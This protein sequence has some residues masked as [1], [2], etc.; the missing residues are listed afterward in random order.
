MR[1]FLFL[2]AA[3][4]LGFAQFSNAQQLKSFTHDNEKYIEELQGFFAQGDSKAAKK[5]IEETF[6]P[7]WNSGHYSPQQKERVYKM[8]DLMLKE[9]KKAVDF[10]NY[11]YALMSFATS[12]KPASDFEAFHDGM[13]QTI[14][15]LS[16][17]G[18]TEYLEVCKGLFTDHILFDSR[19]VKWVA[20]YDAY[21]I[22]FDS[23][24]KIVFGKLDLKAYSKRDSSVIYGTEGVYY[25]TLTKWVGKGGKVDWRRAGFD[26]N[27]TYADIDNYVIN[28]T[29]SQYAIDSVTFHHPDYLDRPH[30][31]ILTEK[32]LAD[33]DTSDA[34]YPRF[35]SYDKRIR[36][37]NMY[38][39]I[40]YAGGFSQHGIKFIG[41]GDADQ[42]ATLI[43]KKKNHITKENEDFLEARAKSFVIRPDKVLS[44]KAEIA[45]YYEG[46]SIY[47]PGLKLNYNV[48]DHELTLS[49]ERE[50][51]GRS[52]FFDSYHKVDM[53]VDEI[54]WPMAEDWMDLANTTGGAES[55]ALF[56]SETYYD[57]YRYDRLAGT[58]D[59]HPL[60]KI[61]N[62]AKQ[63]GM[64]ELSV[65]QVAS[66]FKADISDT[67]VFLM[68]LSNSG[69]MTYNYDKERVVIKPRLHH[70]VLSRSK[71]TDYDIL[72]FESTIEGMPNAKLNLLN[73]DMDMNGVGR[74]FLSDSQNVVIF[75]YE[76]EL[77][78]KKNRDFAFDGKVIGGRLD[79]FGHE[80]YFSFDDFKI[81]LNKIDSLRLKVPDGVPDE[82]GRQK[83]RAVKTVLRDLT[84]ELLVDRPD[85]KSGLVDHSRYPVFN[86]TDDSF[87]YYDKRSIQDGVYDKEKFYMHLKPFSIDSLEN[88]TKEGLSFGGNFVSAGIFPDFEETLTLQPDF[89]LGFVRET[90]PDGLDMYGGK[91]NYKATIKLSH[92]GLR[93]DGN[94][95]YLTSVSKSDDFIFYPDSVNGVAQ[96]FTIAKQ[97][98]PTPYPPVVG[99]DV[100]V[101]W[102]PKLDHFY[103]YKIDNAFD[104]YEGEV[105]HH[106][107]LDLSPKGLDGFGN[108]DFADSY[109]RSDRFN[110]KYRDFHADS[111]DFKLK[112][113]SATA[114]A[115][116]TAN[117][118]MDIDLNERK[119]RFKSN[120]GGDFVDFPVNQYICYIDEFVWNI[121]AKDIDVVSEGEGSRYVSTSPGQDSLE[122]KSPL[123]KFDLN[124]FII[125]AEKVDH[126]DVADAIIYP[127]SGKVTIRQSAKMD[128]LENSK[129]V[130]NRITKFHTFYESNVNVLG[131]YNYNGNGKYDYEDVTGGKQL[132]DFATIG[133]D[134]AKQTFAVG[135]IT[136]EAA[137]TLSPNFDYK[138]KAKL[139][140]SQEHLTYDGSTRIKHDCPGITR[141]WLAFEANIDPNEIYIPIPDDPKDAS[142]KP[143]SSGVVISKDST[144]VYPTFLSMKKAANDIDIVAASGYLHFDNESQEYRISNK[145]KL[146]GAVVGGNYVSL[147]NECI[148]RGQGLLN[149]GMDF[150]QVELTPLGNVE[151]NMNNDSTKFKLY[152]GVDFFFNDECLRIMADRLVN[153]FP[154]LDAVFYG[155]EYEKALI[156]LIGKEET[157]KLIQELNLYGTFKKFPKE[158]QKTMF[159]TDVELAWNAETGSYRYKGFI[160]I[161]SVGK[162]QVNKMVYGLVELTKKRNGDELSI[163]FEPSD[164]SWYF[165]NYKRGM[166]GAFSSHD[167]FNAQIR[168][169][170]DDKRTKS[171]EKGKPKITYV[172]STAIQRRNFVRSFEE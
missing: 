119:G 14:N 146:Q 80:F 79:F 102:M 133:V 166:L 172:L 116:K 67:K 40:D 38:K 23:L 74:V 103:S 76:Q 22:Q 59:T 135:N 122:W 51:S 147:S 65:E 69:F 20:K 114:D 18:F 161:A 61:R 134:S 123:A 53:H 43:F 138:G 129:I 72:Q 47:H 99:K 132:I 46:D 131:K 87:V 50:G 98:S 70:Y 33:V 140:A 60:W 62:Y 107:G 31:G 120:T 111:A 54:K 139:F 113:T 78:L 137:F 16:R 128:P 143:M 25:P 48:E 142:G 45:M 37:E 163:Y 145:E 36:I 125:S 115:F 52:P 83:L 168:D 10:E 82:N 5:L 97:Q 96:D 141:D 30:L 6:L 162:F 57:E 109:M 104:M 171:A 160:G 66:L 117:V 44:K 108:L 29:K 100:R 165:F 130:A 15:K 159:L 4:T 136:E 73:W 164:D 34:S 105:A 150:G 56:E 28:T 121:D 55:S 92:D 156:E 169:T 63:I 42:P 58:S 153:H 91:G 9:R 19:A 3:F 64:D 1:Q 126:I 148:A 68:N 26:P 27:K 85:N 155:T 2:F 95:E 112:G 75:P 12:M 17:K 127:D 21:K 84:G 90:P 24:P 77:T 101:H 157:T 35:D 151:H 7:V 86:S 49:K 106:G 32:I 170:K 167:D 158:L 41:S 81:Q 39:D 149:M 71:K 124:N 88:F 154:P 110:F 152:M 8:S 11:L 144:V 13:E 93:G 118:R 89:S 94:L